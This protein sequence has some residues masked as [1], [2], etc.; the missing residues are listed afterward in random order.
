MSDKSRQNGEQPAAPTIW[1]SSQG[2]GWRTD[3]GLSKRETIAMH[4]MGDIVREMMGRRN[5]PGYTESGAIYEAAN[6]AKLSA[7]ALLEALE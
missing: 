7:D 4:V 5:E 1:D 6:L 2:S 3:G